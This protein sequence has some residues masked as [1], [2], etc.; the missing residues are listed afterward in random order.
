M[1][2]QFGAGEMVVVM[3]HTSLQTG[4]GFLPSCTSAS[5]SNLFGYDR[6][7]P[8][9]PSPS[10]RGRGVRVPEACGQKPLTLPL[11]PASL[12]LSV[13]PEARRSVYVPP[14]VGEKLTGAEPVGARAAQKT[15]TRDGKDVTMSS[16]LW[17]SGTMSARVR[18][19][20]SPGGKLDV[21]STL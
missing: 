13:A 16:R 8:L 4:D 20:S 6:E 10:G 19:G 15:C 17:S 18:P 11:A 7:E 5:P 21:V 3:D 1:P 9:A 12:R 2:R 14:R